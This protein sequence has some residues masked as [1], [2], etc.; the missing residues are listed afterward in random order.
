M[1]GIE[2][3]GFTIRRQEWLDEVVLDITTY[4]SLDKEEFMRMLQKYE[5]PSTYI[6]LQYIYCIYIY[7]CY[8]YIIILY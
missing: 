3:A 2:L 1:Q 4:N 8:S 5:A 7:I 6:D